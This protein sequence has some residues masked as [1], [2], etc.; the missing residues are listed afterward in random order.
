MATLVIREDVSVVHDAE[1]LHKACQGWGTDEKAII[2]ILGH[3]NAAHRQQIRIAYNDIYHEDLVKR[4]ESELSGDFEKAV[5]RWILD[6]V[7]RQAVLAHVAIKKSEPDYHVIVEIACVLSP[8]EL[9]A[10]RRAYHLRYKR[11]LEEDVAAATSGD[12]RKLLWALVS[13]FRYDGSEVNA[14]LADTEA[15]ILHNA[16][17]DKALNQEEA[18][19]ILTTRSKLQLIATF[20]SYRDEHRTSIT[21]QTLL[22]TSDDEFFKALRTTIQCINDYK[23]Y[24]E[25]VL[26]NAI[27]KVGT[28]EDALTRV[29]VTRAERDLQDIKELYYKRNSV[30]LDQAVAND[31]S[32]DYKKFLLTLLGKED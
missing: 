16:I 25:K 12:I 23:K 29:I 20:N 10:V 4:L 24:Y 6:P 8:E 32:G 14:R 3:R 31:I 30:T 2:N 22:G 21:K 7:D 26:R 1:L 15:E 11:S 27:K 9:L 28:D 5:Y 13:S 19:R 18:I 17:K